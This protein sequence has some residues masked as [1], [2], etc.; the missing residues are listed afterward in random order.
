[1]TETT[2]LILSGMVFFIG[3]VSMIV[4]KGETGIGWAIFGMLCIWF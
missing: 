2:K 4:S 3:T 1:M